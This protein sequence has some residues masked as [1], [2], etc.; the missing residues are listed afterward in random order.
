[1]EKS[2]YSLVRGVLLLALAGC[3][4]GEPGDQAAGDPAARDGRSDGTAMV[5]EA[6]PE[7]A[8]EPATEAATEAVSAAA[9]PGAGADSAQAAAQAA[10]AEQPADAGAGQA[11]QV[12]ATGE[13]ESAAAGTDEASLYDVNCPEGAAAAEQCEVNKETYIGWRTYASQCFQC[14]G[15]NGVG[16]T[17]APSLLDRLNQRVDYDRFVDVVLNGYR[18]QMGAMPAWKGNSQVEPNLENLWRYLKARA[19]GVLPGG[20]PGRKQ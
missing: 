9:D 14:H 19:D 8:A 17:F 3:S 18:G 13:Q 5:A 2:G 16:T 6:A 7:P 1:M 4:N 11:A 15:A 10:P 20:R 12:T